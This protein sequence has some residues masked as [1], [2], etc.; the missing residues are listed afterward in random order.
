MSNDSVLSYANEIF[1]LGLF[2]LEY[3]DAIKEGDG[4][5]IHRCW[6]YMLLLFRVSNKVKYS[7]KAYNLLAH[8]H[9]LYSE[10]MCRQ[11]LWSRTINVHGKPGKI[12]PMD[13]HM[14]HLNRDLK[15]VV[16]HLGLIPLDHLYK[17]TVTDS[18]CL[19][20]SLCTSAQ[21]IS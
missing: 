20:R 17:E 15:I 11:L 21:G 18:R 2:L 14:E 9:Y 19:Q 13:L 5:R 1:S 7:L 10:R 12:I 6:K 3:I 16:S 8:Y 4:D